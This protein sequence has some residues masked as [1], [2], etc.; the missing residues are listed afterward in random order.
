MNIEGVNI[1]T[2]ALGQAMSGVNWSSVI[3]GIA[4]ILGIYVGLAFFG[5]LFIAWWKKMGWPVGRLLEVFQD[6]PDTD[7]KARLSVTRYAMALVITAF[8]NWVSYIV[9][10]THTLE[11]MVLLLVGSIILGLYHLNTTDY[12]TVFSNFLNRN[13][14][15]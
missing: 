15:N 14:P 11:G 3:E 1:S 9:Y 10:I 5:T 2:T 7:G 6:A 13:K 8:V 12:T 4:V